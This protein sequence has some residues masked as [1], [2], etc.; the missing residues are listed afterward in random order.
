MQN[1]GSRKKLPRGS[2]KPL[3]ANFGAKDFSRARG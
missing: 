2:C 1:L 3:D